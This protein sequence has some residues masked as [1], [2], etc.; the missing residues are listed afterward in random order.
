MT[1][2]PRRP[3]KLRF[4]TLEDRTT[5]TSSTVTTLSDVVDPND[6]VTSLR[7][8]VAAA[9]ADP[10][11]D[12]IDFAPA[13]VGGTIS[14]TQFD[15]GLDDGE[16]GPSAFEITTPITI[17]GSGQVITRGTGEVGNFRLFFVE[18]GGDL[19]LENLEL[20]GG[21]AV[22]GNGVNGGG[23]AAGLGGAI[24]NMGTL[25]V[26]NSLL[27]NNTARGGNGGLSGQGA[28]GGG[29]LGQAG[30]ISDGGGT[31]GGGPNGGTTGGE[32][33]PNGGFGGGGAGGNETNGGAGGFGGGGGGGT[34]GGAGGNGGFG[35]GGGGT[36]SEA[37]PG[38]GGFGGVDGSA[39]TGGP[40]A[41][42]G[43]AVFNLNGMVNIVN[44]TVTGNGALGGNAPEVLINTPADSYGGGV[45]NLNGTL[46]V[47]NSTFAANYANF[48]GSVYNLAHD[49]SEGVPLV[50]PPA[51]QLNPNAGP[52]R[53]GSEADAT[54]A[55]SIF[56]DLAPPAGFF[57]DA[58]LPTDEVHNAVFTSG[59]VSG[60]VL[61]ARLDASAPNVTNG[62]GFVNDTGGTAD[63]S[64]LIIATHRVVND[65][66]DNG[67]L[68]RTM[69]TV[70]GPLSDGGSPALNAG[71]TA[72][73]V[74]PVTGQP[75][76]TD[77]RGGTFARVSGPQVDLGA[78][79]SQEQIIDNPPPPPSGTPDTLVFTSPT[80]VVIQKGD[81]STTTSDPF[82]GFDGETRT[83]V[84]DAD[85]DGAP[86]YVFT[87][88]GGGG[89]QVLV[90][91]GADGH[92]LYNFFAYDPSFRGG[93]FT[94]VGDIDRDG[95]PDI[96][97]GAG[98]GGGPHVRVFSGKDGSVIADFFAYDPAFRGGVS[99]AV[100]DVTGDGTPDIVTGPGP[101]GGSQVLVIDGTKLHD[102]DPATGQIQ[103]AAV[104]GSFFAFDPSFLGGVFVATGN[105]DGD[106]FADIVVGPLTSGSPR[107]VVFTGAALQQVNSL[108][109]SDPGLRTGLR[110][111][112]ADTDGDGIDELVVVAGPGGGPEEVVIDPLTGRV[113]KSV[114]FDDPNLRTGF[115]V[116]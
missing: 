104:A 20:T 100:G 113:V 3:A 59:S 22:G 107:A 43:G 94:A 39:A 51:A 49:A 30:T 96:V 98:A 61:I 1:L 4:E 76:T 101:G 24:F 84:G 25:T 78:F 74:D 53:F 80:K 8:A 69:A 10:G 33:H 2:P 60:G 35:G 109:A 47:V 102:R 72:A 31:S 5:P 108:F 18:S 19:T 111:T 115:G 77:Q 106:R 54:L 90:V 23:G 91:S 110:F 41:G 13:L 88:G 103:A 45:F 36:T 66:A 28:G 48:G 116:G 55:N 44:S 105:L 92:V 58:V 83:S 12:T 62:G 29:G 68:T 27:D 6:G 99:V 50:A 67:G 11:A 40:G 38:A 42:M 85:H 46:F 86:D 52:N 81:G 32:G 79:E 7:E 71:S 87:A 93:V 75:L 57:F 112:L 114:F 14:L 97:T 21:R 89:P 34:F 70:G 17:H 73:A 65:L 82:P 15:T 26:R 95:T 37:A 16:V 56:V 64:G 9:E 63:T